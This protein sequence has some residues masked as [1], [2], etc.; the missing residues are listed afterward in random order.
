M[1]EI[2]A[3]KKCVATMEKFLAVLEA[4]NIRLRLENSQ[5]KFELS[6]YQSIMIN[7]APKSGTGLT[8]SPTDGLTIV[9]Y[10]QYTPSPVTPPTDTSF[11]I[12]SENVSTTLKK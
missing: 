3:L 7:P 10:G 4:D 9:P 6:K 12:S 8:W 2:E 5:L 1:S 11:I